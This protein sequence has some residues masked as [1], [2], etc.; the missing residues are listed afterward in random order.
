MGQGKRGGGMTGWIDTLDA[1][2][3][4]GR[5]A[6]VV[7]LAVA[8][9]STPRAAGTRMI[10]AGAEIFGSIGGGHLEFKA[11]EIAR[12][13][14][15]EVGAHWR[16]F[17]LG[18]ALGQ[19][20][21]GRARLLFE[22]VPAR[23]IAGWRAVLD[24]LRGLGEPGVLIT[25]TLDAGRGGK[26][27]VTGAR[28]VG[29]LGGGV[30][31]EDAICAAR[32]MLRRGE[33]EPRLR[34][35]GGTGKILLEV[36]RP[37]DF[38]I[39][40][41]GAGHVGRALVQVLSG[42]PCRIRWVDSRADQF[43]AALPANVAREVS[44]APEYEVEAAPGGSCFLVMTHSHALDLRL[45]ERILRRGDFFYFGLIGSASKRK[46]FENRLRNKGLAPEALRRMTCPIGVEGIAGKHPAEIAVA[47]AAEILQLRD[48]LARGAGESPSIDHLSA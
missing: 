2:E 36:V 5:D 28:S 16:D 30:L 38:H 41:F 4:D 12:G 29:S 34:K 8:E 19:C 18:P 11:I 31:E 9:G 3:R 15:G 14:L 44:D 25:A 6:V 17:P 27:L 13:L 40:L 10:V 46:R 48:S 37:E 32:E 21:G 1:L 47:V 24:A 22:T 26:A 7:T 33:R 45:S 39:L 42:L 23:G 43:P 35:I 20:C